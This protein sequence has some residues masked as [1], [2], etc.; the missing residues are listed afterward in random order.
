MLK[1][2]IAETGGI[3]AISEPDFLRAFLTIRKSG[4]ARAAQSR[5]AEVWRASARRVDALL[6]LLDRNPDLD[7]PVEVT[8]AD[9]HVVVALTARPV[10]S[11]RLLSVPEWLR[12]RKGS[13]R[14]RRAGLTVALRSSLPHPTACPCAAVVIDFRQ[15]P[16]VEQLPIA[17]PLQHQP[18]QR[19][20]N[21]LLF[22][23]SEGD[24]GGREIDGHEEHSRT[25]SPEVLSDRTARRD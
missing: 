13:R 17:E 1:R 10:A 18:P 21:S 11:E 3:D 22:S 16:T 20:A 19:D 25:A 8:N 7:P 5:D 14:R 15:R 6:N 24:D 4:P 2:T 12:G 9:V 23:S